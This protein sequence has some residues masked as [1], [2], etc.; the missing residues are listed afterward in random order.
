MLEYTIPTILTLSRISLILLLLVVFYLPWEY[1]NIACAVI[2]SIA[3]FTDW[4]DGYLA[5]KW[6]METVFGAFL[7]PVAD[8]L[9]VAIVLVLIVEQESS[10][11]ATIPAA[12]IIGREITVASLR[13][14]MAELGQRSKVAVSNL[15]K[16]KTSTQ[17]IAMGCL[18]FNQNLWFLPIR[19]IGYVLLYIAAVL[20]I[21]SMYN[22][23]KV[24]LKSVLIE[25]KI[26]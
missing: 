6:Q 13:E 15:G 4:L 9:L 7:D 20:T 16:W 14:W 5:R 21:L 23:L 8:K 19:E 26:D 17:M 22:Y 2:F 10:I 24:A 11:W 18:L 1:A 12:I 25:A 3:G